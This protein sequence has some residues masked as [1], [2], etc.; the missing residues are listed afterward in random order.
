MIMGVMPLNESDAAAQ[1]GINVSTGKSDE[2]NLKLTG[3]YK[4]SSRNYPELRT[5]ADIMMNG[6]DGGD[7]MLV[8]NEV[9][10][11]L[12]SFCGKV[13]AWFFMWDTQM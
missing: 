1:L 7:V 8:D 13:L 2:Q 11:G 4:S 9:T 3:S 6:G 5:E 12:D 10:S